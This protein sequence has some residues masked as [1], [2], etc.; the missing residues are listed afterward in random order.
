MRRHNATAKRQ[1]SALAVGFLNNA[2]LPADLSERLT[3]PVQQLLQE[4]FVVDAAAPSAVETVDAS[5]TSEHLE[6]QHVLVARTALALPAFEA[7]VRNQEVRARTLPFELG[8]DNR[9]TRSNDTSEK[10]EGMH[11][12]NAALADE[13]D[14]LKREATDKER[15]VEELAVR[16]EEGQQE[17]RGAMVKAQYTHARVHAMEQM[18]ATL[19]D[20]CEHQDDEAA[21][22][23]FMKERLEHYLR[24]RR[25]SADDLKAEG[26]RLDRE[27]ARLYASQG[28]LA[29]LGQKMATGTRKFRTFLELERKGRHRQL[30]ERRKLAAKSAAERDRRLEH[31]R[32]VKRRAELEALSLSDAQTKTASFRSQLV[33]A[34]RESSL[35]SAAAADSAMRTLA[36]KLS[37][38]PDRVLERLVGLQSEQCQ[39]EERVE[40]AVRRRDSLTT[41]LADA[42]HECETLRHAEADGKLDG[43]TPLEMSQHEAALERRLRDAQGHCARERSRYEQLHTLLGATIFFCRSLQARVPMKAAS[44]PR[45]T[46]AIE[47]LVTESK[48]PLAG[49]SEEE[50][51]EKVNATVGSAGVHVVE[52]D[53]KSDCED[54]AAAESTTDAGHAPD[55]CCSGL[56]VGTLEDTHEVGAATPTPALDGTDTGS[57]SPQRTLRFSSA[58]P[59]AEPSPSPRAQTKAVTL[60][61]RLSDTLDSLVPYARLTPANLAADRAPPAPPHSHE[62]SPSPSH[63]TAKYSFHAIARPTQR[64]RTKAMTSGVARSA[65]P[66]G[67]AARTAGRQGAPFSLSVPSYAALAT[68]GVSASSAAHASLPKTHASAPTLADRPG[69]PVIT[70]GRSARPSSAQPS[71]SCDPATQDYNLRVRLNAAGVP[72]SAMGGFGAWRDLRACELLE[73]GGA[74]DDDEV[75]EHA[76]SANCEDQYAD[77][78]NFHHFKQFTINAIV[79]EKRGVVGFSKTRRRDP[80]AHTAQWVKEIAGVKQREL[81]VI[82]ARERPNSA[83]GF[84][85]PPRQS[86]TLTTSPPR[87]GSPQELACGTTVANACSRKALSTSA[88][89]VLTGGTDAA[90][91][92]ASASQPTLPTRRKHAASMAATAG[93]SKAKPRK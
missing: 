58:S 7:T 55:E 39:L 22:L 44:L 43:R 1:M 63:D 23:T 52:A 25:E 20:A 76:G 83:A 91:L 51:T 54:A 69:A 74:A 45:S 60:L 26:D 90:K 82:K 40:G 33:K 57:P 32:E 77:D 6:F 84:Q 92:G 29:Q 50:R 28:N 93:D 14:A 34:L 9:R 89:G 86:P 11:E 75:Y 67:V 66:D 42:S 88:T 31:E 65:G 24:S 61:R 2:E 3:G 53:G 16:M 38:P 21:T 46:S 85:L 15:R 71:G 12:R 49:E 8:E 10:K 81:A 4:G 70:T 35:N 64:L 78:I 72:V 41:S 27:N 73:D 56:D 79:H 68:A 62:A 18:Y 5:A 59:E 36:S 19:D 13:L 17:A 37:I 47:G 30:L 80:H 87:R 48:K